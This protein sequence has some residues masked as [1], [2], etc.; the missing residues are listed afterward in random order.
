LT[1]ET[2][3][4]YRPERDGTVTAPLVATR[5]LADQ[6][7]RLDA[8]LA[9]YIPPR[10]EWTP[11]D[12]ALFGV[13]DMFRT[14][15]AQAEA[16]Q[17]RAIRHAFARQYSLNPTYRRYC[18]QRD[19]APDDIKTP[20]DL[21]RIPLV[22]DAFFKSYPA[23][24]D[25][26]AWLGNVFTGELPRVVVRGRTPSFQ[27]VVAAFNAAGL[28][29][30]HS[31]G[32]GGRHTV[33]PRDRRTYLTSQYAIA[34]AAVT[35]TGARWD[36]GVHGY[37]LMPNPRKTDVFAGKVAGVYFDAIADVRVAI[38]RH[39]SAD[40]VRA[41]VS[42]R[43]GLRARLL[44]QLIR[45]G[46][47]RM[48]DRIVRWLEHH[49]DRTS[50]TLALVGA[51][52]IVSWVMDRLERRGR[53]LDLGGRAG[54][55][56]GGGFKIYEGQRITSAEFRARARKVLGINEA[57]CLDI[58]GMVE[59]NGWMIHCPEGH[60]FHAP[61]SYYKPMV[62]DA[63]LR[64]L[65]YGARGRFAFL[66]GSAGSYPGFV[67]TGDLVRMLEHCPACD[68]P[69]P[70]LEPEIVRA[71]GEDARGCAEE[72]RRLLTAASAGGAP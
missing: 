28:V 27:Q 68:R 47:A 14:P 9:G 50:H 44:R 30:T 32:T 45:L 57:Y 6:I 17:L 24:R 62:L 39:V 56:T 13:T 25:F 63:D 15:L 58:Y 8:R 70:V 33:I 38:D 11:A 42:G 35:M 3:G 10:A 59:G 21:A 67:V 49:H 36:P 22:P 69:G 7:A 29:I 26:A 40:V 60:Y 54:I 66:D 34:K 18:R 71:A 72:M 2:P 12:E 48:V 52:F 41:A 4:R 65:P 43:G 55:I 31:S 23:G 19:I 51:P 1:P 61:Y 16:M 46:Q 37:L 53:R 5:P 64:P 20:E